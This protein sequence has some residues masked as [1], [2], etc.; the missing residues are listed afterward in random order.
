VRALVSFLKLSLVLS[1]AT[2][3][4]TASS[5]HLLDQEATVGGIQVTVSVFQVTRNQYMID[6]AFKSNSYPVGCLSVYRDFHYTLVDS[7]NRVVPVNDETLAHPPWEGQVISPVVKGVTPKSCEQRAVG[8]YWPARAL[9]SDLYPNVQPGNYTLIIT[10][11]PHGVAQQVQ[12]HP[13][14]ITIVPVRSK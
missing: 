6:A 5:W 8:G 4:G 10:I 3:C 1:A 12:L 2:L 7:S 13:V 11:A 14:H 9:F